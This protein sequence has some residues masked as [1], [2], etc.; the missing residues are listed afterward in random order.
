MIGKEGRDGGCESGKAT[1][2]S[3]F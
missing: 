2:T 1:W 3:G